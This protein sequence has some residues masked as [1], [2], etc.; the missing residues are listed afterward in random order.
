MLRQPGRSCARPEQRTGWATWKRGAKREQQNGT[1]D[2][3]GH[4]TFSAVIERWGRAS[5]RSSAC[6][7]T[8]ANA[9]KVSSSPVLKPSEVA[10]IL[11]TLGF[12]MVRQRGS[13]KQFRDS[14]GRCIT[15]RQI[16]KDIGMTVDVFLSY[17]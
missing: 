17:R 15:G 10:D 1:S 14:R 6:S 3:G 2:A 13:H 4:A 7:W 12:V 11:R 5:R 8:M 9:G 16:A